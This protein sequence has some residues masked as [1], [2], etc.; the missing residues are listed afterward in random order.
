MPAYVVPP[1]QFARF[2]AKFHGDGEDPLPRV[3]A[4]L[5][6]GVVVILAIMRLSSGLGMAN[7]GT[8]ATSTV[9]STGN[10]QYLRKPRIDLQDEFLQVRVDGDW[11]DVDV[12]Y[13]LLN[14]GKADKVTYGFPIDTAS[15]Y[16][17]HNLEES[18]ENFEIRD[19]GLRLDITKIIKK[20]TDVKDTDYTE[21]VYGKLTRN[22]FMTTLQFARGETKTLS[23]R[24]RVRSMGS[25]TG[26]SKSH[27]WTQSPRVFTYTF[28]PAATWGSGRVRHLEMV[29]DTSALAAA[30]IPVNEITPPGS[31]N[32]DGKL[33]WNLENADLVQTPD[34]VVN[35]DNEVRQR[36]AQATAGRLDPKLI[37]S[38]DVSS[39]HAPAEKVSYEARNLFDGRVDT[40]WVTGGAGTG[41]GQWIEVTFKRPI[42]LYGIGILNGLP[43]SPESLAEHGQV[44]EA[45][46]HIYDVERRDWEGKGTVM[47]TDFNSAVHSMPG[48]SVQW[49]FESVMRVKRFRMTIT[50]A[51]PGKRY[52]QTAISELYIYGSPTGP[53]NSD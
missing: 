17:P 25:E 38:I 26:T 9:N 31:R 39:T 44:T 24:Y 21:H 40:A 10:L 41:R 22:W 1:S 53:S 11:A 47:K 52:P 2:Y 36:H 49:P 27:F 28:K 18:I 16:V 20:A 51:V 7:G 43:I 8:F 33:H 46:F 19:G 23:V 42:H 12:R 34:L 35:Y 48:A 14:R 45:G 13:T 15:G 3:S 5:M 4:S 30:R 6:R 37:Q 32:N 29:V 50:K